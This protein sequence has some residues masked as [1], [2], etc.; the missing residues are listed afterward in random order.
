MYGS[1]QNHNNN[2]YNYKAYKLNQICTMSF[3]VEYNNSS[4]DLRIF[5]GY[6]TSSVLAFET[7]F[8]YF[9]ESCNMDSSTR[10]KNKK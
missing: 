9:H 5:Q 8:L 3:S 2:T 1:R 4:H 7:P 6:G 10:S